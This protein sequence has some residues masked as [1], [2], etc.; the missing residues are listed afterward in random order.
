VDSYKVPA[1]A[2]GVYVGGTY[3]A[4][5]VRAAQGTPAFRPTQL[6]FT[7]PQP[8]KSLEEYKSTRTHKESDGSESTRPSPSPKRAFTFEDPMRS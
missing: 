5:L 1:A 3:P 6:A 8:R 4:T 2:Q 7:T